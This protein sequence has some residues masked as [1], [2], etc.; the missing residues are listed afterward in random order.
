MLDEDMAE[1]FDRIE[2]SSAFL[3]HEH[4]SQ[5]NAQRPDVAPEGKFFVG[6]GGV[7]RQFG[8]TGYRSAFDPER[9]VSHGSF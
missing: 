1:L 5:E 6:I 8:E 3:F 4:A 7:C 2:E 9:V